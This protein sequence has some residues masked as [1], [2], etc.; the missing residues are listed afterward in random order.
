MRTELI[1]YKYTGSAMVGIILFRN[2]WSIITMWSLSMCQHVNAFFYAR[3]YFGSPFCVFFCL[4]DVKLFVHSNLDH[5]SKPP[6]FLA[7]NFVSHE[8]VLWWIILSGRPLHL[9][10]TWERTLICVLE[11]EPEIITWQKISKKI[12]ED[13]HFLVATFMK[14]WLFQLFH[15]SGCFIW[16]YI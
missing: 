10:M 13:T 12:R 2:L 3:L 14:V 7:L 4:W 6:D 11:K 1:F 16:N 9:L 5:T 15:H 8:N